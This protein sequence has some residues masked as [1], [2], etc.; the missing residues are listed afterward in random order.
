MAV[1]GDTK[2]YGEAR[3][4]PMNKDEWI[5]S[6]KKKQKIEQRIARKLMRTLSSSTVA[7]VDRYDGGKSLARTRRVIGHRVAIL[8]HAETD[9]DEE[10]GDG[11][12]RR[13]KGK[14]GPRK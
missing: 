3:Y 9:G 6:W 11:R 13:R 14:D 12:V 5:A 10:R 2:A 8:E 7:A 1:H 4:W